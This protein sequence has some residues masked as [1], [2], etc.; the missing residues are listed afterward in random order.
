MLRI[1]WA[2]K[3]LKDMRR[4]ADPDRQRVIAKVEQYARAPTSLANNVVQLAGSRYR[5]LR[6]GDYRV[7]FVI[8]GRTTVVVLRVRHRRHAY[9]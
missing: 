5:R 4:L 2:T 9:D 3:A 1:Q 6:V 7:L 8:E